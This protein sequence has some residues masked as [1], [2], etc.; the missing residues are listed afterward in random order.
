[1][2]ASPPLRPSH[3]PGERLLC[4]EGH[5]GTVNSVAWN[6]ADPQMFASASDDKSIHIWQTAAAVQRGG[7]SSPNGGGEPLLTQ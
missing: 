6:P 4:L 1:M 7:V 2:P 3:P 5:S